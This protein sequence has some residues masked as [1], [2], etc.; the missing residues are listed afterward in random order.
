METPSPCRTSPN[1]SAAQLASQGNPASSAG[2]TTKVGSQAQ[3]RKSELFARFDVKETSFHV[4]TGR[5]DLHLC[6]DTLSGREPMVQ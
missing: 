6:D 3:Q 2:M 1:L 4:Y 5:I